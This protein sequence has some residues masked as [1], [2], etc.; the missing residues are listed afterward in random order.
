MYAEDKRDGEP[1]PLASHEVLAELIE[2]AGDLI[3][4]PTNWFKLAPKFHGQYCME[5]ALSQVLYDTIFLANDARGFALACVN[6]AVQRMYPQY[7]PHFTCR[8]AMFNDLGSTTH[9]DVMLVMSVAS[10]IARQELGGISVMIQQA[11][12]KGAEFGAPA[13][14]KYIT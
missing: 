2:R 3:A 1:L 8:P 11:C 4:H 13:G 6:T 14:S 9:D 7:H 10:E 5:S 12:T